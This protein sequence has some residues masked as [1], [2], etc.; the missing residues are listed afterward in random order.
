LGHLVAKAAHQQEQLRD[1]QRDFDQARAG[2][3]IY[4]F[5]FFI[6]RSPYR[7]YISSSLSNSWF[8]IFGQIN[9]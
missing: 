1:L 3:L 7:L 5:T 9:E 4:C 2:P 8:I 6:L